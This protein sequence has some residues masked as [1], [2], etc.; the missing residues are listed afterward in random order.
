MFLVCKFMLIGSR[1]GHPGGICG[2]NICNL[3]LFPFTSNAPKCIWWPGSAHTLWG[4]LQRS[5][6]PLS[7][8]KV[9]VMEEG[10]EEVTKGRES[11]SRFTGGW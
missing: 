6:R 3:K 4:S 5:P 2:A 7:W 10:T 11:R 8:I 9:E 1:R